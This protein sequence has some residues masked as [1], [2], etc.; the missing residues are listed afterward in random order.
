MTLNQVLNRIRIIVQ[1]HKQIRSYKLAL[2]TDFFADKETKYP[3]CCLQYISG[4][5][6]TTGI[7]AITLSFRM[8]LV[9]LVHVSEDT[10][11]NTDDVLSDMLS[12]LMDIIAELNNGNF[13]DWALS[14]ANNLQ[15]VTDG[16]GE[17]E[18]DMQAGWTMDFNI[19]FPFPQNLCYIPTEIF[20]TTPSDN[21]DMKLVYD[22]EYI[23]TGDEGNSITVPVVTGKKILLV[24][25]E[26]SPVHKVNANPDPAEY[27]WN[28]A[29]IGLGTVTN[30]GE[31]FLIL[32]RNY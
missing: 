2:P 27:T 12:I 24:T 14:F 3:A 21:T 8:F 23:A 5:I 31:R 20:N 22:T 17:H 18:N 10:K 29:V 16:E 13:N 4:Q 1:A 30:P 6:G 15:V 26:N 25:R 11:D 28:D 9:D 7:S 19:R 32:Y